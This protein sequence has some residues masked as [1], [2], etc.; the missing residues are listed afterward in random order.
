MERPQLGAW[1]LTPYLW[2]SGA[3]FAQ[4]KQGKVTVKLTVAKG[5]QENGSPALRRAVAAD[6][7]LRRE[8]R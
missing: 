7:Q 4:S 6:G 8:R 1:H 5:Y 3:A 2:V